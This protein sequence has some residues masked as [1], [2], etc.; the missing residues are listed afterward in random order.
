L[1]SRRTAHQIA[2]VPL[3]LNADRRVEIC[4]ITSRSTGRWIIPKGWPMKGLRDDDAAAVEAEE[5]AGLT[6]TMLRPSLG[7][8]RY[9]RR[10]RLLFRRQRVEVF[11][12]RVK[13]QRKHW[14]E[15]HQRQVLWVPLHDAIDLVLEPSLGALLTRLPRDSSACAFIGRGKA[16]RF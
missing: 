6:G 5:E 10:T 2:A 9:W 15:Q 16:I 12:L 14:K 13:R 1:D 8:F 4:L 7:S 3:R 11:L